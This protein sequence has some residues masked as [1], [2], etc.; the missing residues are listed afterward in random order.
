VSPFFYNFAAAKPF[1]LLYT[2]QKITFQEKLMKKT[3]LV[4]LCALFTLSVTMHDLLA[5]EPEAQ[6]TRLKAKPAHLS[7]FKNGSGLLWLTVTLPSTENATYQVYPLPQATLGGFWLLGPEDVEL[8][9]IKITKTLVD[10]KIP[11]ASFED[12]LQANIGNNVDIKI[13]DL[14]QQVRIK[15]LPKKYDKPI[16]RSHEIGIIPPPP[17]PGVGDLLL[18]E[19]DSYI[20]G[21]PLKDIKEIRMDKSAS[22]YELTLPKEEESLHFSVKFKSII[23]N[24]QLT[25]LCLVKG[26]TWMPSYVV[27]IS[28]EAK[29][30][31]TAKSIIVND[32][33]PF[34]D[35]SVELITGTPHLAHNHIAS[36]FSF[37]PLQQIMERI[38]AGAPVVH[39]A[40]DYGVTS[41]RLIR[42]EAAPAIGMVGGS[43][44]ISG[45]HTEDLFFYE[46][47]KVSLQKG[48][49]GYHRVFS[50]EVPYEHLYSWDIANQIDTYSRFGR[51]QPE[52]DTE[53]VWHSLR[54][55]NT[56]R[57]PW[58]TAP[59]MTMKNNRILGQDTIHYTPASVESELKIT[60]A[61]AVK[62]EQNE[63]EIK[64]MANV[65]SFYG[66]NHDLVTIKGELQV[67]NYKED[68]INLK[69][70]KT[71]SGT[72][73]DA[74]GNPEIK[75]IASG[76]GQTN[77]SG[78]M[79]WNLEIKP[80][81][82]HQKKLEYT[83]TVYVQH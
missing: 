2:L 77:P 14:W 80:G 50:A 62:A 53:M 21:I 57:N 42:A 81:L 22:R 60:K 30:R 12:L 1:N 46:L 72:V 24:P 82:E 48:E 3:A 33:I 13:G 8:N 83:Y 59:A 69:I 78:Q 5:K 4:F 73:Q 38:Q 49:R 19:K 16:L 23:R 11:A 52:Q 18:V 27:D 71:F 39:A 61:A 31:I 26:A 58:T 43:G 29:A 34:D 70:T 55:Q 65:G 9:S 63:Y 76:L 67:T 15:A 7:L 47:E 28:D 40:F 66:R 10:E 6:F 54:L 41:N 35:I 74:E 45:E 25:L 17:P 44:E 79:I 32:L 37:A 20:S 64:R 68:A 36:A 56:T 75:K 51:S